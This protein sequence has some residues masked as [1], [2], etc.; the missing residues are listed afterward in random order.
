MSWLIYGYKEK[1]SQKVCY[2]GQTSN[3]EY[4]RYKH[5]KYDP[6]H[7]NIPEY[8]YPLSRG[9]RKHGIEYYEYFIIEKDIQDDIETIEREA[10]WINFYNTYNQGFNQTPGGKAPKYIKFDK[11]IIELAKQMLK[12]KFSFNDI[13]TETGISV[14]HL[15]QINTGK[16]HHN[17]KENYP[18]NSMTCGRLLSNQDIEEITELLKNTKISQKVIGEK[19]NVT[20]TCIS[21]INLG[22][23]Y[24]NDSLDYPIRK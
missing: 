14:P 19:F 22:K 6:Y 1:E 4:R 11:E 23:S 3:E 9:I 2:I 7:E 21:Q 10:F 13:A 12:D 5:E 15:S 18:L 17:D 16:R 24:K 8:D 20:Q